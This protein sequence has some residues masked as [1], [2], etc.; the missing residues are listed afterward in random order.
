MIQISQEHNS[1]SIILNVDIINTSSDRHDLV[2]LKR[3]ISLQLKAIYHARI[4][5]YNLSIIVNSTVLYRVGNCSSK[6]IL[7]QI[8]DELQGNNPAEADFK[9][10]R[11]QLNKAAVNDMIYNRNIRTIPH[12]LGHLFGWAHPHARAKYESVNPEAHPL[13]QQLTEEERRHNLMS[14]GWYAQRAGIPLDKA[15]NISEKQIELLLLNYRSRLLN[16][17]FHLRGMLFWK[18]LLN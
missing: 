10:L 9:G 8:V 13:E 5:K 6:R 12:E 17:N 18:K 4:G 7:F 3:A 15:M 16:R 14:Q 1:I 11:I 2:A